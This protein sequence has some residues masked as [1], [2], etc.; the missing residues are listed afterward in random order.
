MSEK[1]FY[2]FSEKKGAAL[3]AAPSFILYKLKE[4]ELNL[5]TSRYGKT[6]V[7]FS[8]QRRAAIF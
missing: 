1:S 2:K 8:C 3:K 7:S 4:L 6:I 5:D